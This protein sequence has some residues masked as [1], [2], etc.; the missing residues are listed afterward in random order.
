M[1]TQEIINN[2]LKIEQVSDEELE[3]IELACEKLAY[4]QNKINNNAYRR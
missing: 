2:L 1:K 3:V 4:L